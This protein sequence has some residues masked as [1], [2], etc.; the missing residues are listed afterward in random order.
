[1]NITHLL[2]RRR[3]QLK[4][5]LGANSVQ[6]IEEAKLQASALGC[7]VDEATATVIEKLVTKPVEVLEPKEQQDEEAESTI[8]E[9][10]TVIPQ[11]EELPKKPSRKALAKTPSHQD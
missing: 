8:L 6:T 5:W 7:F 1:M 11:Q 2:S 3:I 9:Q 10:P 4:D